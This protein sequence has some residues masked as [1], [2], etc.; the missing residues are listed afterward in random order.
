MQHAHRNWWHHFSPKNKAANFAIN[1]NTLAPP[2]QKGIPHPRS[3]IPD[4]DFPAHETPMTCI[5]AYK[6]TTTTTGN[7]VRKCVHNL[8]EVVSIKFLD[9]YSHRTAYL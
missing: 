7:E 6:Q 4:P 9:T 8:V 3:P 5:C 1:R 2:P